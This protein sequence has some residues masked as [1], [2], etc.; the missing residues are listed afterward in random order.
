M[1]TVLRH[2]ENS[3]K[4]LLDWPASCNGAIKMTE[5][6]LSVFLALRRTYTRHRC[7][8]DEATQFLTHFYP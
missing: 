7:T 3:Y 8:R 2:V 1:R 4:T 5:F 6:F